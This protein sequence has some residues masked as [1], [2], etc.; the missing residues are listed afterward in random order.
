MDR[1]VKSAYEVYFKYQDEYMAECVR[2]FHLYYLT[3]SHISSK[4]IQKLTE[5]FFK[6]RKLT[7]DDGIDLP[8]MLRYNEENVKEKH[9]RQILNP[10]TG[11][12]LNRMKPRVP[13]IQKKLEKAPFNIQKKDCDAQFMVFNTCMTLEAFLVTLC[14]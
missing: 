2:I 5:K 9:W 7:N 6:D 8:A 11:D 1:I 12:C 3:E 14:I 10:V 13:S 4:F